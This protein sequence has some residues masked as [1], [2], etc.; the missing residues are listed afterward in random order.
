MPV[1]GSVWVDGSQL[2]WIDSLGAVR[3]KTGADQGAVPGLP[4]SLWIEDDTLAYVD[5]TGQK[6][7]IVGDDLGAVSGRVGSLWLE[8]DV[9]HWIDAKRRKRR[10]QIVTE[11]VVVAFAAHQVLDMEPGPDGAGDM[12]GGQADF[13]GSAFSAHLVVGS[14]NPSG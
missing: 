8:A 4:G 13:Y 6:R 3:G 7:T 14:D 9:P 12:A 5:A 11:A 1:A 10:L 2:L